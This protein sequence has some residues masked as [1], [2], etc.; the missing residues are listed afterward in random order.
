[1]ARVDYDAGKVFGALLA[2]SIDHIVK[3]R[4][5]LKRWYDAADV[6]TST[7]GPRDFT[8]IENDAFGVSGGQGETVWNAVVSIKTL[9]DGQDAGGLATFT[10]SLDNGG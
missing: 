10:A 1:M 9:L 5:G 7:G 3:G 4:G 2:E 8:K 6:A